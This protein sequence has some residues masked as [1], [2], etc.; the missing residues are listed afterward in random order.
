M[1]RVTLVALVIVA[2][3]FFFVISRLHSHFAEHADQVA[4]ARA[5]DQERRAQA[6]DASRQR[7]I[8]EQHLAW[9]R[10]HPAEYARQR[11]EAVAAAQRLEREH[12]VQERKALAAEAAAKEAEQGKERVA[13]NAENANEA[14]E[15]SEV[16]A[17]IPSSALVQS[18]TISDAKLGLVVDRDVW[19][20][21]SRQ[22]KKLFCNQVNPIWDSIYAKNHSGPAKDT[23]VMLVDL[24]GELVTSVG[25]CWVW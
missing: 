5:A 25:A 17:D 9:Q 14:A 15:E 11:A 18:F 2:L 24:N 4:A 23:Y 20:A 7:A 10:A 19:D 22:D 21:M 1:N 3:L 12:I 16:S 8:H 13:A 6:Q